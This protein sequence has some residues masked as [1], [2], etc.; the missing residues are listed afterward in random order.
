MKKS[1]ADMPDKQCTAGA[2]G[3]APELPAWKAFVVQFSREADGT[4]GCFTGRV[5]HLSSGERARFE[6]KA[7]LLAIL[8]RMLEGVVRASD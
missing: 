3:L 8:A 2:T 4:L 1:P 5:E 6:T 7:D